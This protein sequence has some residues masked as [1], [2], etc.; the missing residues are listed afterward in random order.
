MASGT[1]PAMDQGIRAAMTITL[2]SSASAIS[3]LSSIRPEQSWCV[4]IVASVWLQA[5]IDVAV[6]IMTII[7]DEGSFLPIA[8]M[9]ALRL[10][11]RPVAENIP[12]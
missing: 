3:F 11:S 5:I 12:A 1:L 4:S 10:S 7:T 2:F 6:E 8:A 9:A